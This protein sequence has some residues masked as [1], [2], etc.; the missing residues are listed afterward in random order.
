M[1]VAGGTKSTTVNAIVPAPGELL[2]SADG[3]GTWTDVTDAP[4]VDDVY[5]MECPT[6]AVCAMVG[7]HWAGNPPVAT[8]A[9]AQSTDGAGTFEA[10]SAAYIPITLRALS[11]PTPAGCVAVGGDTV[12]RITLVLPQQ[13]RHSHASAHS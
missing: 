8:G 2:R 9:V 5:D 6:A 10:S 4:P 13:P 12:A 3:G 1:C 11:C 7:T